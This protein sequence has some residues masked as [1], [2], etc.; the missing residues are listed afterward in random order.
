M[1]KQRTISW[2]ATT[3]T[4]G[5]GKRLGGQIPSET[6]ELSTESLIVTIPQDPLLTSVHQ[7][8]QIQGEISSI[9]TLIEYLTI[10]SGTISYS[11]FFYPG[12]F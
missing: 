3:M 6:L 4:N 5:G 11:Q 7:E 1:W 9:S 12:K 2:I 10:P 8:S